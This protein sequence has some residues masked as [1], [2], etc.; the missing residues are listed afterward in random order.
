[1]DNIMTLEH[2]P[3]L[4]ASPVE[5]AAPKIAAG[6]LPLMAF[7]DAESE[8]MLQESSASFGRH[9]IQ[10]GGIEKAIDYLNQQRSPQLLIVDISGVDMPLSLIH[11]L[12]DVCEPGTDVVALGDRDS[13]ALYRDLVEAG[14]SNY[15]VKPL[16]RDLISKLLSPKRVVTKTGL[17]LG[18]V[19]SFVGARG[20]V[21]TTTMAANLAWH[22]ANRQGRRVALVDLGLQDGDCALLFNAPITPGFWEA[23]QN[24]LR[25]D[26]ILLDRIMTQVS[27]RL[28]V[29]AAQEPLDANVQFTASAIDTLFSVLRSKFHY[30]IVDVPH[31]QAPAYRRALEM[32][33]RRIVVVDQ[34]MRAMRDAVRITNLFNDGM[35][36][37]R[38]SFVVNRVGEAGGNALTMKD[39]ETVLQA[40]PASLIPFA[41][42]LVSP[43]ASYGEIAASKRGNFGNAVNKLSLELSGS[44][45]RRKWWRIK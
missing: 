37:Q 7:V 19:M 45:Q 4:L 35:P 31:V 11:T 8:R 5:E 2:T 18:K 33:D 39:L 6:R 28:F 1:M 22:L 36:D 32:A 15:I 34:T 21:G 13:V 25:L 17:K 3:L 10:K 20:G 30:V 44:R 9:L 24:P 42:K 40:K 26:H 41:P 43:A 16:T 38:N 29:I 23:L 14:V 27:E 12:A